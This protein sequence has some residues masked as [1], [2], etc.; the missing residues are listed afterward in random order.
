MT[1]GARHGHG[2]TLLELLI[3]VSIFAI[4]AVVAYGALS[5]VLSTR[6]RAGVQIQHLRQLQMAYVMMQR[7]VEQAVQRGVRDNFG[8]PEPAMLGG[9]DA[10][11][12]LELTRLGWRNPTGEPRSFMQRVAYEVKDHALVRHYWT[13]L[14]RTQQSTAQ[15]NTLLDDID[16]VDV[17]FMDQNSQWQTQWPPLSQS[18][19]TTQNQV[20]LPRAVQVTVNTQYWGAVTWLFRVP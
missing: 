3:A 13:E 14:D 8:D 17:K 20:A 1:T 5:T 6:A 10:D 4:L 2:F 11:V 9:N 16:G 15:D 12:T 7:D 19:A 18:S